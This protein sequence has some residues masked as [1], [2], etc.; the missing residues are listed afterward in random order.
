MMDEEMK[1]NQSEKIS[2]KKYQDPSRLIVK[3][4]ALVM[5]VCM[6]FAVAATCIFYLRYYI[7]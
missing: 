4:V 7:K 6:V 1:E 3:I 5:V 2:K